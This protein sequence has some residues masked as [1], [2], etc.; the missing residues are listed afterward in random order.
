MGRALPLGRGGSKVSPGRARATAGA[1]QSPAAEGPSPPP[2]RARPGSPRA[3]RLIPRLLP[4][5][6]SGK[7]RVSIVFVSVRFF[8]GGVALLEKLLRA[9]T[10]LKW[11]WKRCCW[12][13]HLVG[14]LSHLVRELL[15]LRD[16]EEVLRV[17]YQQRLLHL[18]EW[19]RVK[20][21]Q[22]VCVGDRSARGYHQIDFV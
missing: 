10:L 8:G 1:T 19:T 4:V 16:V 20:M 18:G 11:L 22:K 15:A 5:F 14:Y 9:K 7:M 21:C 3:A 13:D 2:A 12:Q 6:F 17:L